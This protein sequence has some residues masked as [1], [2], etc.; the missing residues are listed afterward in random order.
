MLKKFDG[1]FEKLETKASF[2]NG[3]GILKESKKY[4]IFFTSALIIV[5]LVL[6]IAES[7]YYL[8]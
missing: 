4:K 3:E 5:F 1:N 8:F 7:V 6:C 2:D